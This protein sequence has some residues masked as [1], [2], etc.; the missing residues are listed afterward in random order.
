MKNKNQSSKELFERANKVL[1]GGVSRNTIY[2][3]PHP[4]YVETAK[5]SYIT[6]IDGQTRVDFAN[7]MASLIHGHSN[8]EI[9]NAVTKQLNKGTAYTMG[10][11]A[12]VKFAE[13]LTSRNNN[14]EKISFMNYV[15]E[16]VMSMIKASSDFY[17]NKKIAKDRIHDNATERIRLQ[18]Q[19]G[20]RSKIWFIDDIEPEN[21]SDG[22][23]KIL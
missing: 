7:N 8:Q 11:I 12:E 1:T 19:N 16:A 4:N 5:G 13:L 6:E 9:I 18:K 23:G 20:K 15:T 2:R 21:Y 22:I 10:S 14:Y 3:E 17:G